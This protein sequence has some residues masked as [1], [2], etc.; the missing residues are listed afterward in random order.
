MSGPLVN[1][2]APPEADAPAPS[3][4][5]RGRVR[6]RARYLR[7]LRDLQLRDL[8]GFL[9]ELHRFGRQRPDLVQEKLEQASRTD[10]ELRALERALG[11]PQPERE[12]RLA[13]IGGNC[14]S[15]GTVHGSSD[16]FCAS[17]GHEL[18]DEPGPRDGRRHVE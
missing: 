17:C 5:Q 14:S 16:R 6:R 15:C 18:A 12:L 4:L 13:G 2:A 11:S 3:F 1:G 10:R 9:V 7:Q 8:G